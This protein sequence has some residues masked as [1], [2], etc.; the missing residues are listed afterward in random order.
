[1]T[2]RLFLNFIA[3]LLRIAPFA[4]HQLL[5]SNLLSRKKH[6]LCRFYQVHFQQKVVSL[7]FTRNNGFGFSTSRHILYA[8]LLIRPTLSRCNADYANPTRR[9]TAWRYRIRGFC[10]VIAVFGTKQSL[11]KQQS[12]NIL[13]HDTRPL[14][15]TINLFILVSTLNFLCPQSPK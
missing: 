6:T 2:K 11:S 1:L 4:R 5:L 3:L 15:K 14:S 9:Q 7:H 10:I 12:K 13:T 8:L